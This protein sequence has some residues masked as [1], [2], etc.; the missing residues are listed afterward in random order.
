[1]ET[2]RACLSVSGIE[3]CQKRVLDFYSMICQSMLYFKQ[4][5]M[6]FC[7]VASVTLPLRVTQTVLS[8]SPP[9]WSG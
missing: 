3:D 8:P 5:E 6:K 2:V 7:G 4:D 1:M 9:T